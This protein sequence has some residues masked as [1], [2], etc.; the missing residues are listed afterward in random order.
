MATLKGRVLLGWMTRDQAVHFLLNECVHNPVIDAAAAEAIWQSYRDTV[1]ALPARAPA[2]PANL[3][4]TLP[5]V[6][7][8]T[9]FRKFLASQGPTDV[10]DVKKI[11]LSAL[12]V[13]Q[14]MVVTDRSAGYQQ[15]VSTS[16]GW[17]K[18]CL[19]TSVVDLPIQIYE[20]RTGLQSTEARIEIPHAE[21]VFLTDPAGNFRPRQWQRHVTTMV[22]ADRMFL[23][24][25]Y[26][27]SFARVFTMPAATVPS[28]VVAVA[29]NTLVSPTL[30]TVAPGLPPATVD[31]LCPFGT[32][33][34]TF[35]DFFTNGLFMEVD[36]R[37]RRYLLQVNATVIAEDD[38]T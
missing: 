36:L 33:A 30:P 5:E 3:G 27:R 22:G 8:W 29:V 2:V 16:A 4:L 7:H 14:Y 34:A 23:T 11:D 32:K 38:P 9:A 6:A 37:K 12:T 21:F 31:P 28:A 10:V 1:N 35:A 25:G 20:Q 15:Q 17:L 24:A 26:H 19:P 18:E 13:V